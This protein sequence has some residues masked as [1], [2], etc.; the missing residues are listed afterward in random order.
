M[1]KIKRRIVTKKLKL[2][3][4][5]SATTGVVDMKNCIPCRPILSF[6]SLLPT[7]FLV[8]AKSFT[9]PPFSSSYSSFFF[10][11]FFS[12]IHTL[13]FIYFFFFL[14]FLFLFYFF[15]AIWFKKAATITPQY[16]C[17]LEKKGERGKKKKKKQTHHGKRE[18]SSFKWHWGLR[19]YF[20]FFFFFRTCP[21]SG[22]LCSGR[23]HISLF[24]FL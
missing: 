22:P 11:S 24:F 12:W 13:L 16:R 20:F 4:T 3:K 9:P 8:A 1:A 18:I 15:W 17:A 14:L 2:K 5:Y 19:V 7:P 10:S 23:P 21:L 6:P